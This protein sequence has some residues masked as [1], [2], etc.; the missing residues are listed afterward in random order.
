MGVVLIRLETPASKLFCSC[1]E[2]GAGTCELL[3]SQCGEGK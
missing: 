3:M 1:A 2:L